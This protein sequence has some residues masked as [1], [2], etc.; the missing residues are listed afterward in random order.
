MGLPDFKDYYQISKFHV[1]K[2]IERFMKM[3]RARG[4]LRAPRKIERFHELSARGAG[5][6][7]S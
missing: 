1:L 4:L 3:I 5:T 6:V 2:L 7:P